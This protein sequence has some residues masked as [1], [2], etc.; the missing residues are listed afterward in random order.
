MPSSPNACFAGPRMYSSTTGRGGRAGPHRG[1]A[2]RVDRYGRREPAQHHRASDVRPATCARARARRVLG[3][4]RGTALRELGD[5]NR[6]PE[7]SYL[8][9]EIS[10]AAVAALFRAAAELFRAKPWKTVPSD[11]SLFSVT[12]PKLG[13]RDAV[14]SVIE[15]MDRAWG[16]SCSPASMTSMP[17]SM[18]LVRSRMGS[19]RRCRRAGAYPWL[20]AVDQDLIARPPTAKR[21]SR[22]PRPSRSRC[23][24]C[25]R[26]RRCSSPRGAL[27]VSNRALADLDSIA[28]KALASALRPRQECGGCPP[29]WMPGRK[30]WGALAPSDSRP[31]SQ[32]WATVAAATTSHCARCSAGATIRCGL[33]LEASLDVASAPAMLIYDSVSSAAYVVPP[34][35]ACSLQ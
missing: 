13:V 17:I 10:P 4:R 19:S 8:S 29:I 26:R 7:Q 6:E 33:V 28:L 11:Q 23:P 24:R 16:S 22:S 31:L 27:S 12:L 18:R 34:K 21:R 35:P 2:R 30:R 9:P 5:R 25:S 1:Q 20:V 3:A 15:Q 32:R 14:L